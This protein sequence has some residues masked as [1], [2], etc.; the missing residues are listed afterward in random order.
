MV[1]ELGCTSNVELVPGHDVNAWADGE[2]VVIS[3]GIVAQC[4]TDD[5][6]A[7][8]IAHELA[9]NLLRHSHKLAV[10]GRTESRVMGL[11]GTG[12][13]MMRETEEEAD[14]L[15]VRM[16][17]AAAYDVAKAGAFM[18]RLLGGPNAA[19]TAGT[20]PTTD[21]RLTLLRAEIAAARGLSPERQPH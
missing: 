4:V 18:S 16:T 21:R 7:L 15:A 14:R 3:A 10:T 6:L 8:V 12:S 11:L 2:R 19:S 17:T 1:P 13:E 5:D 9:H 20:H